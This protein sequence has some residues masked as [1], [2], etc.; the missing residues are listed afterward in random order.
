MRIKPYPIKRLFTRASL[1]VVGYS[2][3]VMLAVSTFASGVAMA[4]VLVVDT[5][6]KVGAVL[7]VTP[8]DDP[9]AGATTGI[10]YEVQTKE[11]LEKSI[12]NL[13]IKSDTGSIQESIPVSTHGRTIA[14]A[15]DFPIRGLYYI[16]LTITPQ[17]S[18]PI[19]FHT[20][21]RVTQ[22]I[23]GA[24]AANPVPVWA[25]AGLILSVWSL[26]LLSIAGFR[27]R[28]QIVKQSR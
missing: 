8:D 26:F 3:A 18:A 11:S 5:T 1:V 6:G 9:I 10:Y 25:N 22:G 24:S 4:H 14:S 21:E 27:H 20:S 16:D 7:H 2:L 19:I 17:D 28:K 23:S 15:F 13:T 12:I